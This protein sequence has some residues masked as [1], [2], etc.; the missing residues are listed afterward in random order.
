MDAE[1][2]SQEKL[3]LVQRFKYITPK[4]ITILEAASAYVR[5]HA[6]KDAESIKLCDYSDTVLIP[7]V[8]GEIL[9][10]ELLAAEK[11]NPNKDRWTKILPLLDNVGTY[12]LDEKLIDA[13]FDLRDSKAC[14]YEGWLK[15]INPDYL[16]NHL[17]EERTAH[18]LA[19]KPKVTLAQAAA[20]VQKSAK[21][22]KK[23]KSKKN[24][25]LSQAGEKL[26]SL[27]N[28]KK[29]KNALLDVESL[30]IENNIPLDALHPVHKC[31]LLHWAIASK[32]EARVE[33]LLRFQANPNE[34]T[35]VSNTNYG[36]APL[37]VAI[38][39]RSYGLARLLLEYKAD[40]NIK[41]PTNDR[42]DLTYPL[43]YAASSLFLSRTPEAIQ[44]AQRMIQLLLEK[45]AHAYHAQIC[46]KDPYTDGMQSLQ[47]NDKSGD[48]FL[49]D[50]EMKRDN[51]AETITYE[52]GNLVILG[53]RF[54]LF[55]SNENDDEGSTEVEYTD[56]DDT[57]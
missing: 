28:N 4:R 33:L 31:T 48:K 2:L 10:H 3:V 34:C 39:Q 7:L 25:K 56:S 40:P 44:Q 35:P 8:K 24:T 12:T 37:C 49:L 22:K 47:L 9:F 21:K 5:K 43:S 15:I 11:T 14:S 17:E 50:L 36:I 29:D 51:F 19:T 57:N 23:K 55:D 53:Q 42:T 18:E 46:Y 13:L 6:P 16:P 45:G 26:W 38:V 32:C 20:P 30:L 27:L 1:R 54:K 41:N 52:N